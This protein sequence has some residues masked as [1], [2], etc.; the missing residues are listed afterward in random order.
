MK[1]VDDGTSVNETPKEYATC[2]DDLC[3]KGEFANEGEEFPLGAFLSG[4]EGPE[5]RE[6]RGELVQ[7]HL[8]YLSYCV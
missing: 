1:M 5:L 2:E 7:W 6:D 3:C 4:A 8:C